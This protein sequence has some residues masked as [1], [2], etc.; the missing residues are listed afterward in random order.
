MHSFGIKGNEHLYE[1]VIKCYE[2][3]NEVR[4]KHILSIFTWVIIVIYSYLL[5]AEVPKLKVGPLMKLYKNN[6]FRLIFKQQ[7]AE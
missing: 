6:S 3:C 2:V 5:L 7:K 4:R 1:V